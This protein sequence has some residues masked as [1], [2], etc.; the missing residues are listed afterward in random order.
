[1]E[2]SVEAIVLAGGK[3]TRLAPLTEDTPKPLLKV[4]GKSVLENVYDK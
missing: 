4:L 2:S 3:G 1:M